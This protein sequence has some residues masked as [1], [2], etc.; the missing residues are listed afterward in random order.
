MSRAY[1]HDSISLKFVLLVSLIVC[2]SAAHHADWWCGESAIHI[3]VLFLRSKSC[4]HVRFCCGRA[5]RLRRTGSQSAALPA[6]PHHRHC[7]GRC[8]RPPGHLCHRHPHRAQVRSLPPL[9]RRGRRQRV[10]FNDLAL[11]EEPQHH[12]INA[13]RSTVIKKL[14]PFSTMYITMEHTARSLTEQLLTDI[15][16]SCDKACGFA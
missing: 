15:E 10:A 5:C 4:S 2:A 11:L 3:H 6:G 7:A 8:G 14:A 13:E 16:K 1:K 9:P 12:Q